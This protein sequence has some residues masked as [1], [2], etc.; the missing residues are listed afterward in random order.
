M[1]L[2][3]FQQGITGVA[4]LVMANTKITDF[5]MSYYKLYSRGHNSMLIQHITIEIKGAKAL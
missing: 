5:C 3:F 2:F 4:F 1:F